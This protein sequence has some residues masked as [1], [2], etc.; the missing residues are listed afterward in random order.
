MWLEEFEGDGGAG[1]M[2][3]RLQRVLL[4]SGGMET[5]GGV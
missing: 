3:S 2:V 5:W 4:V 1:D